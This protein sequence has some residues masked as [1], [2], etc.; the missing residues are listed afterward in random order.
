MILVSNR[1]PHDPRDDGTF[2]R[3]AGGVVTG[4]LTLAEATSAN[5]VACARTDAERSLAARSHGGITVPLRQA[6]GRLYYASP[7]Q[8][9][10]E[11]YYAVI[12]NPVL[13]FIQHYLWDL[14]AEPVVD[15]RI[16]IAWS[17]GYVEVNRQMAEKVIELSK[18][19]ADPPL[20]LVHDYQLYLVPKLVRT[21]LPNAVIQHFVHVPWPTAQYWKV[22]PKHMRD[23]ILEGILGCDVIGFQT[24]LD[25]RNFLLT[26]EENLGLQVDERERAVVAG[27][28]IVYARHYP[29][30]VDVANGLGAGD[31]F[32]GALCHGLLH[33]L[34]LQ[35]T[36]NL[37]NA[38][39]AL[40]A[41]RRECSLAMPTLADLT[42]FAR[43]A[44]AVGKSDQANPAASA[45]ACSPT[46]L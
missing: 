35:E 45:S 7:T 17:E 36:L 2:R 12:S 34:P 3:G 25:V 30:S 37:A 9:Q 32:G 44:A 8:E 39:G 14:G 19:A 1:G 40:V 24:S 13:W 23:P 31:A 29:I 18:V 26:C 21:A 10:Y 43:N 27:G 5:W 33:G 16:H 28:R 38:A 6:T 20:V 22:L 46:R 11:R 41:T 42:E 4:L 15:Q